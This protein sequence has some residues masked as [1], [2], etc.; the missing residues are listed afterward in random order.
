MAAVSFEPN[1]RGNGRATSRQVSKARRPP[2]PRLS[3]VFLS[4]VLAGFLV[5]CGS[6]TPTPPAPTPLAP[7][8]SPT[9][10]STPTEPP[11]DPVAWSDCG[12][13]FQCGTI[14]APTDYAHPA[15]GNVRLSLIRL[16]AADPAHR[17]GS[18]VVN[19]GGP[20]ASGVDFVRDGARDLFAAE[21]LSRFDIVGFDPRGVNGS[22][23]VRCIDNL[24]HVFAADSTPDN[25]AETRALLSLAREFDDGCQQRAGDLLPY[26]GTESVARDLDR[27]RQAIGD[28]KL[29]YVGFSYGTLIGAM[30]AQLFPHNIR[31][32]VLDGALDPTLDEQALRRGQAIGFETAFNHFL[33]DCAKRSSCV[34]NNGGHPGAAL[35]ALM[36]RIEA[37]P[38]PSIRVTDS[39]LVG[40]TYAWSAVIGSL[41]SKESW[42]VLAAALRLAQEGDG[43]LLLLIADPLNG[44]DRN[45]GY[46][47]LVDANTA[48]NCLDFPAPRDPEAYAAF[49]AALTKKAPRFGAVLGWSDIDC[50]YW[51]V[52]PDRV[53]API[54]APGAPPIVVIGSTF[55]P[56]TPYQWAVAL[57][58]EL[59]SGVLITR[60]GEGHTGYD[61]SSCV[62]KAVDAYLLKLTTPKPGLTCS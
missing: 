53:P 23:E 8:P 5:G 49:A 3:V 11:V 18:L 28:A 56:A 50:A 20:G 9:P 17:I 19:P 21:I 48:V 4:A 47:N 44:R 15:K 24:D 40:P 2:R 55:D 45:G 35:D 37:H 6:V 61:A 54:H 52:P 1:A 46:S 10:G 43:G 22:S 57:S 16:A 27:I 14:L 31:A 32:L 12:N 60:R 38:L 26:I 51:P 42:P 30:Y 62:L 29:T 58:K 36:T 25:A 34:F 13:G 7:T 33:A 41:Y 59:Q 39:R